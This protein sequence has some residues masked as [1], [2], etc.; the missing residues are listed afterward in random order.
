MDHAIR[1]DQV[2]QEKSKEVRQKRKAEVI[3]ERM[4]RENLP[5]FKSVR[6]SHDMD[7][8]EILREPGQVLGIERE[9]ERQAALKKKQVE[10]IQNYGKYVKEMYWRK[11]SEKNQSEMAKL[12]EK[13]LLA[14]VSQTRLKQRKPSYAPGDRP[15]KQD[16]INKSQSQAM[17][18]S[19]KIDVR[20]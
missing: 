4:R 2:R 17:L 12:K 1:Y 10:K 19:R 14:N 13:A 18:P 8:L 16:L 3:A 6:N 9:K 7:G 11:V 20:S 15:W 5:T